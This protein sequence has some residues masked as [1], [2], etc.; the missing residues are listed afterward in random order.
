MAG[1]Q[2]RRFRDENACLDLT[3][4]WYGG[5]RKTALL[6]PRRTCGEDKSQNLT[7]YY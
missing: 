5:A 3:G 7:E 1:L 2:L 4:T 6:R